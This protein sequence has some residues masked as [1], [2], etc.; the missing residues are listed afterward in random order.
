MP[1]SSIYVSK[2]LVFWECFSFTLQ[3]FFT[4]EEISSSVELLGK[5]ATSR[6]DILTPKT[7]EACVQCIGYLSSLNLTEEFYMKLLTQ[8][9]SVGEV[10]SFYFYGKKK[11][12]EE[13]GKG[14][15]KLN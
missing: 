9:C 12:T 4:D 2:Q 10:W 6:K 3:D 14:T 11:F 13:H 5:V 1:S 7:K 15:L 8:M